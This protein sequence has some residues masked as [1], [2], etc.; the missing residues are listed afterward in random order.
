MSNISFNRDSNSSICHGLSC[1][2]HCSSCPFASSVTHTAHKRLRPW[3]W[4]GT[5]RIL[6]TCLRFGRFVPPA[7]DPVEQTSLP[8]YHLT[9]IYFNFPQCPKPIHSPE[10]NP[11]ILITTNT[12][13]L[14]T[15]R[16]WYQLIPTHPLTSY[17]TAFPQMYANFTLSLT[18]NPFQLLIS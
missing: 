6:A 13:Q 4:Q 10:L 2:I 7:P 12:H 11:P 1:C 18:F 15:G 14:L 3:F 16:P 8:W 9:P 17:S 5:I